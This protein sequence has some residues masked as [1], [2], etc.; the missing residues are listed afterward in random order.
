[1]ARRPVL[2]C[3]RV[4]ETLRL[5]R[6]SLSE[7]ELV[8][9]DLHRPECVLAHPDGGILVPDWRGGVT[10]VTA[11]GSQETW[12]A[13]TTKDIRPN[14][15]ATLEDGSF[16]L[17]NLGVDGGVWRLHRDGHLAPFLTDL[18]GTPL[19]PAN[20]VI[21][22]GLGRTWISVSTQRTP[23][24][25]AW[26]PDVADGFIVLVDGTGA[27]VVADGLHYTNEVRPN[28]SG[29][30]LYAVETFGR[31][32]VRFPITRDG[33]LGV[34]ET[35]VTLEHGCFPDG[36]AF[37]AAGGIWITSLV[38]NRLLRVQDG[39]LETVLEDVNQNHVDFVERAFAAGEMRQDHLGPIPG[40]TLQQLTSVAFGGP[41]GRSVFLGSLH[42]RCVYRFRTAVSGA[43][44]VNRRG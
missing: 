20:F 42:G 15:I 19:P 26:R 22:D 11:N 29:E 30:W 44:T 37:D 7:L 24:Q 18:Q 32:L 31:R 40:T 34:R 10:Q 36:F 38:S 5:G 13:R 43:R 25:D 39:T 23:R 9:R 2:P 33:G 12:L 17:A 28:P 3:A 27:R 8:G 35:V 4:N 41:D 16:L 14:G 21:V 1:M 6:V